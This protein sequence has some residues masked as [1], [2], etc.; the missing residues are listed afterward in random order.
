MA[1][2]LDMLQIERSLWNRGFSRVAGVDEAG[3]GPLAGPVV[4]AAVVFPAGQSMLSGIDDSKRLT[5]RQRERFFEAI[6][7]S[8]LAVGVGLADE[9]EIDRINILQATFLAMNRAVM[10]LTAQIDYLLVDGRDM[11]FTDHAGESLIR[12]DA[13]SMSIAAASIIAKVT[14]DRIMAEYDLHYRQ[15]GFAR[16]KGYPTRRHIEAIAQHGYCPIHRRSFRLKRIGLSS[17]GRS[18]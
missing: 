7:K 1:H 9:A 2:P 10:S 8:A 13:R 15:Y 6:Y 17:E 12:G 14:R 11:P 4:A 18:S 3:R 5:P 16:H